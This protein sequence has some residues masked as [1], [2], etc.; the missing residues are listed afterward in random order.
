MARAVADYYEDLLATEGLAPLDGRRPGQRLSRRGAANDVPAA[1]PGKRAAGAAAVD[2]YLTWARDVLAS[3][4]FTTDRQRQVWELFCQGISVRGIGTRLGVSYFAV[5]RALAAVR[6][7]VPAA[8]VPNP[9][10]R[11]AAGARPAVPAPRPPLATLAADADPAVVARALAVCVT[12]VEGLGGDHLA[13]LREALASDSELLPF[14]PGG[15]EPVVVYDD[16]P[17]RRHRSHVR[18]ATDGAT[19]AP[20]PGR[21][22][23]PDEIRCLSNPPMPPKRRRNPLTPPKETR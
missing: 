18:L 2:A 9:W 14:A 12:F 16:E 6:R 5:Y 23:T 17:E 21:R 10:L 15:D 13:H 8:P 11:C 7:E 19:T 22:L 3:H 1:D 4:T 20:S